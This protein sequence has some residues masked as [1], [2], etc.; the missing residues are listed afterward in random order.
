MVESHA[1]FAH[2]LAQTR[3]NVELLVAHRQISETVGEEI[4]SRLSVH[5]ERHLEE[6]S[7]VSLTQQTQR[8]NM[9]PAPAKVEAWAIW[10]WSSEDP[11]DLSF[12]AGE[13][14]EVFT[15]TNADWWTGRNRTGKQGLFP[16]NYVEKLPARSLSPILVPE[17]RKSMMS[18][19]SK[20]S[21]EHRHSSPA[22]PHPSPRAPPHAHY[23]PPA[24][25]YPSAPGAVNYS[26]EPS[27]GPA[28]PQPVP[29]QAGGKKSKFGGLGQVV[30]VVGC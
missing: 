12:E 4:L 26:Y 30:S 22:L 1:L 5:A 6:S 29:Q 3:Q 23:P 18:V 16:S 21:V 25:Y 14:I 28:T 19:H 8:L 11:N 13:V 20:G 9:S 10:G 24:G 7:D 27:A 15:E 17:P 2:I